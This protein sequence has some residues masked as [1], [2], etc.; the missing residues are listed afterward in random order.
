MPEFRVEAI[1][2]DMALEML[3]ISKAF[4]EVLALDDVSFACRA[5]EV[6]AL[7]GENGAGKSTLMKILAGD[8]HPDRGEIRLHGRRVRLNTPAEAQKR[9]IGIIYQEFNL[10]PW[11]SVAEN[12]LL[13]RLPTTRLGAVDWRRALAAAQEPLDRLGVCLDLRARVRDLSVAQQQ[14]VEIAKVLS[15]NAD[16]II[17]DEPSAVLAGHE[18]EQLFNVVRAL[19]RQGVTIIYISHRLDEVFEIADRV[20][21][22]RDGRAIGT[23]AVAEINKPALIR[24]MVG[25]SLDETFPAARGQVGEPLLRVE[26]LSSSKLG[27]H[28]ISF[29]LRRGEILGLAGLVGAGRSEL[30]MALFGVVP[31]ERGSMWLDGQRIAL[32]NPHRTIRLGMALVPEDRKQ[33]GLVLGQSVRSNASLAILDRLRRGLLIDARREAGIIQKQV[34]DLDIKT[35]SL[36]QEVGYLSGG[37][38]QKVVLAKWLCSEP[39]LII[40]DEPTRG[41]DVGTKAEIYQLMRQ[42]ADNSNGIIMISSELPEI[43]GMSDRVLV[44]SRGRIAGE[45]ARAEA[46]EERILTLAVGEELAAPCDTA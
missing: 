7:V 14:L 45:L 11:L 38:Q 5:G 16:L 32:G 3:G 39:R 24:M 10:L 41:I 15:L 18:L 29:T 9:G 21:V 22:L 17:M 30:A 42:L 33:Q 43:T 2:A 25:R 20:T 40:M 6:H 35:P 37:N 13:G 34:A 46:T 31:V 1:M 28:D 4:R 27:L 19:N 26:G 44:M 8:L 12:I 23:H 36:E